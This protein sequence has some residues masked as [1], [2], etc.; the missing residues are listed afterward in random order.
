MKKLAV[1]SLWIFSIFVVFFVTCF[2]LFQLTSLDKIITVYFY[3]GC[4]IILFS[5]IVSLLYTILFIKLKLFSSII[6]LVSLNFCLF[7]LTIGYFGVIPVSL[8]RSI[9]V[10]L[11]GYMYQHQEPLSKEEMEEVFL[12]KYMKEY[13]AMDRRIHEQ[14]ISGNIV[15]DNE[16]KVCLSE[17]GKSFIESSIMISKIFNTEDKFLVPTKN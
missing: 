17:Q 8:D 2:S 10:F 15:V 9:S 6:N 16:G 5:F 4:S 1:K 13:H 14:Q 3:K 7:C 12:E 11:L